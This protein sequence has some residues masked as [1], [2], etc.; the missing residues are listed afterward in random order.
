MM[1]VVL[2]VLDLHYSASC[3]LKM[4]YFDENN[5]R[6]LGVVLVIFRLCGIRR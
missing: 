5:S 1:E 6:G 4:T 2:L 3:N